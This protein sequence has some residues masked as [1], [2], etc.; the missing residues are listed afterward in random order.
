VQALRARLAPIEVLHAGWYLTLAL[1]E[2]VQCRTGGTRAKFDRY[3]SNPETQWAFGHAGGD[4]HYQETAALLDAV[5]G[6]SR[7]STALEI[8]CGGGAFTEL[9]A[10]RCER[11]VGADVSRLAL[12]HACSRKTLQQR[13]TFMQLDLQTASLPG[14][15]DLIVAM[16]VLYYINRPWVLRA[17]VVKLIAALC[18]GGHLLVSHGK[19]I[20]SVEHGRLAA[21]FLHGASQI[22][23]LFA[24]NPLLEPLLTRQSEQRFTSLFRKHVVMR[25]A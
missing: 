13:V 11:L 3:L 12:A 17:C 14:Q 10:D 7:F 21:R 20:P 15:F 23:G 22:D 24:S 1:A 4:E 25:A 6:N 8:G 5:R 19:V 2:I 16:D 18:P 9:L